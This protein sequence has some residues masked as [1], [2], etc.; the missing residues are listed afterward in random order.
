MPVPVSQLLDNQEKLY[1]VLEV[2]EFL[3]VDPHTVR[4]LFGNEP[5]VLVLGPTETTRKQR[6]YR[7]LR[8][9]AAA[10]NR[11]CARFGKK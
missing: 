1:T 2:A 6:K 7:Q 5:D 4:K 10:L 11:V 3:R 8:I 9:T